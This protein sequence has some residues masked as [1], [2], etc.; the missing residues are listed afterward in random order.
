MHK[1][2]HP[3]SRIKLYWKDHFN[4]KSLIIFVAPVSIAILIGMLFNLSQTVEHLSLSLITQTTEKTVREMDDFFEPVSDNLKVVR[5]WGA[6][7]QLNSFDPDSLNRRLIPIMNQNPYISSMILANTQGKEYMLM[8]E[9]NSWLNRRAEPQGDSLFIKRIRW[10]YDS[11]FRGE[12]DTQWID[13]VAY[14]PRKRP[15]FNA[16][17]RT[18]TA[19]DPAWTK[20]YIFFTTKDPG[21]T[22]S[23]HYLPPAQKDSFV[24]AFDMMFTDLSSF[25]ASIKTTSN[26]MAFIITDDDRVLGLP[27]HEKFKHA[28]SAKKY[29]LKNYSDLDIPSLSQAVDQWKRKGKAAGTFSFKADGSN[30]WAGFHLFQMD[31]NNGFF[32][33]VILPED[34][35]LSEMN[36]TRAV[37]IAGF[38]LVII[39]TLLVIRGYNQKQKAYQ[40]LQEQNKQILAQKEEIENQRDHIKQQSNEI[41]SSIRYAKRIQSAVLPPISLIEENLHKNFILYKPRDI[42]SGD[43][44]WTHSSGNI[45]MWAAADCTG[46]GVPG[47]FL[48]IIGHKALDQAVNEFNLTMPNELLDKLCDII[49]DT[50]RQSDAE[51][52]LGEIK[53]GMDISLCVFNSN[54][55]TLYF[56]AANNPL[57]LI[58]KN[59]S[60]P[61]CNEQELHPRITGN[62]HALFEIKADKQPVGLYVT[63]KAF[64]LHKI[65]LQADDC[66]YTFSDGYADQFGGPKGKKFMSKNFKKLLLSA[67]GK[68]MKD[69]QKLLEKA[70]DDWCKNVAQ[71][72]DVLVFGVRI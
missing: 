55:Q 41:T 23:M 56:S 10:V 39:L 65:K 9:K 43:F 5:N 50:F 59:G 27:A 35:F 18:A 1:A 14:D 69:Q 52:G 46:H 66:L 34:D 6:S 60:L 29:V 48:S 54:T 71:V 63:R 36:R 45:T 64:S 37:I 62:G 15:W 72:D 38:L 13:P 8:R 4:F 11:L 68:K 31:K 17:L 42:V 19:S 57:Y 47:A 61:V 30:W 21:I 49:D 3:F 67:Q 53:D 22:A 2:S 28:D 20:P 24:V 25:T 70:F 32:I 16:G 44:Y 12:I 58:R 51:I 33:G 26:G 7:G 40:L